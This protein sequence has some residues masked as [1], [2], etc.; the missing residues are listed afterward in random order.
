MVISEDVQKGP[1]DWNSNHQKSTS[2]CTNSYMFSSEMYRRKPAA[3]Y[4][5]VDPDFKPLPKYGHFSEPTP[6][7]TQAKAG[8]DAIFT[9]PEVTDFAVLR[10]LGP[11]PDAAIPAGGPDRNRDVV[12]EKLQFPARDGHMIELKV[13]RSPKASNNATLMLR[14]HGGGMCRISNAASRSLL[15]LSM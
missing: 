10:A 4:A 14:M 12:T 15:R 6:E 9:P 5:V 8:I 3:E 2:P 11:A 13:Y 1:A 7:F